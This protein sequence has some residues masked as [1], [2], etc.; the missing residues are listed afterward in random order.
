MARRH[1]RADVIYWVTG[2][3][4]DRSDIDKHL[5]LSVGIVFCPGCIESLGDAAIQ[6]Q[7]ASTL[8]TVMPPYLMGKTQ[9]RKVSLVCEGIYL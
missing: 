3:V 7:H 2:E 8:V 4:W 1:G 6:P 9:M 5:C